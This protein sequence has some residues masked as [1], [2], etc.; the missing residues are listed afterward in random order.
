MRLGGGCCRNMRCRM[1]VGCG[2]KVGRLFWGMGIM[3]I[4]GGFLRRRGFILGC[5]SG[6]NS[7]LRRPTFFRDKKSRQKSLSLAARGF[8]WRQCF[9][10]RRPPSPARAVPTPHL[11][12]HTPPSRPTA[13]APTAQRPTPPGGVFKFLS[14]VGFLH[15]A[16]KSIAQR[17]T[18]PGG[19]NGFTK[20]RIFLGVS[21]RRCLR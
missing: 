13:T 21:R 16:T 18:P 7:C 11:V 9:Y 15:A 20:S 6:I 1:R 3:G 12:F 2:L 14:G 10:G 17:P 5:L 19:R 8:H 4:V